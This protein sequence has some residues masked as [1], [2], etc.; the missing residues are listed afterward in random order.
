[1][2]EEVL[3]PLRF[4]IITILQAGLVLYSS[5]FTRLYLRTTDPNWSFGGTALPASFAASM[6]NYGIWLMLV[7]ILYSVWTLADSSKADQDYYANRRL[8]VAGTIIVFCLV[9]AAIGTTVSTLSI[10]TNL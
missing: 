1:M 2:N 9:M 6:S 8:V 5:G 4:R 7:P 3:I 10:T